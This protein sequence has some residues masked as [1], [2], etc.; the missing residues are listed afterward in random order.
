[1]EKAAQ[2]MILPMQFQ[3]IHRINQ[4]VNNLKKNQLFKNIIKIQ[5]PYK[6]S[7]IQCLIKHIVKINIT[8]IINSLKNSN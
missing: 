8:L 3:V 4:I 5:C 6:S 2:M 1:M 7:I